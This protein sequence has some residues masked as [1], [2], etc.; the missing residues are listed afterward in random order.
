MKTKT[1][2]I[3]FTVLVLLIACYCL[4]NEAYRIKTMREEYD[5]KD[6]MTQNYIVKDDFLKESEF[7]ELQNKITTVPLDENPLSYGFQNSYG[8][9]FCFSL[10]DIG[11]KLDEFEMGFL[12]PLI[13]SILNP[14]A[15]YFIFNILEITPLT[16]KDKKWFFNP[17][18]VHMHYDNTITDYVDLNSEK[19]FLPV[20]VN[21]FYLRCPKKTKKDAFL[22]RTDH[23]IEFQYNARMNFHKKNDTSRN[24]DT[25]GPIISSEAIMKKFTD[26]YN[27][28]KNRIVKIQ[29]ELEKLKSQKQQSDSS[30][31]NKVTSSNPQ[32]SIPGPDR[33]IE[34]LRNKRL[35]KIR[36]NPNDDLMCIIIFCFLVD[37]NHVNGG[38]DIDLCVRTMSNDGFT[39]YKRGSRDSGDFLKNY[40]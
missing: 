28:Y 26:N 22:L 23:D 6:Y 8:K 40:R 5:F 24:M 29:S 19:D 15:N 31:Q 37:Y 16:I 7:K 13:Q 27:D 30:D 3:I 17:M 4:S 21:V 34:Q 20:C 32:Q 39:D 36:A 12:E 9:V 38:S 33:S 2:I 18:S 11:E 10:F 1:F 25:E 35:K 14:N